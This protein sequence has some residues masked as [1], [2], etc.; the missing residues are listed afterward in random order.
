MTP[1]RRALRWSLAERYASLLIG[2]A[3]AMVIARVLTPAEIGVFSLCAAFVAIA[4]TVRDFGVTE[5]I[6]QEKDLSRE[7]LRNVF[8]VALIT[9]WSLGA[10]IFLIRGFVADHYSNPAIEG[11]MAIMALNFLVLPLASPTWAL[12][13]RDMAF[14][15][16]FYVQLAC[17]VVQSGTTITLAVLGFGPESLAWGSLA[18]ILLQA[19]A[20]NL[21]RPWQA[22]LWPSLRGASQVLRYGAYQMSAQLLEAG[23]NNAHEFLIARSFGFSPVGL[24]SRA[25]GLVDMFQNNITVAII[26]VASVALAQSSREGEQLAPLFARGTTMFTGIAWPFFGALAI[27]APEII[28]VLFG[29]QWGSAHSIGTILAVSILPAGLFALGPAVLTATGMVQ[30]RLRVALI[31]CPVHL[32]LLVAASQVSLEAMAL[33]WFVTNCVL[34]AA[35]AAQLVKVLGVSLSTLYAGVSRSALVAAC[36]TGTMALIEFLGDWLSVPPL[37]VLPF[38]YAFGVLAWVAAVRLFRHPVSSEIDRSLRLL[39]DRLG[40]AGRPPLG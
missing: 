31:W 29:P 11:V 32:A 25:K 7:R 9:A 16:M 36:S 40:R 17:T 21:M 26:R 10:L 20:I 12:L 35:Y 8:A 14:R 37:V 5:Y 38:A 2:I 15:Q 13:N 30:R 6:V 19:V 39:R 22:V 1:F 3:A 27:M 34:A 28:Q 18:S 23:T 33:C 4:G 24:F